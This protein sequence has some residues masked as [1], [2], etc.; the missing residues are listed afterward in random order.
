MIKLAC[1]F[2]LSVTSQ[3]SNYVD[4]DFVLTHL[5]LDNQQYREFYKQRKTYKI[6][7]NSIFELGEAVSNSKLFEALEIIKPNVII[8]PDVLKDSAKT[9]NRTK[10]FLSEFSSKNTFNCTIAG[11]L[12]GTSLSDLIQC[13]NFY[14]SEPLINTICIPFDLN[15]IELTNPNLS[16]ELNWLVQRVFLTDFIEKSGLVCSNYN[17]HLLGVGLPVEVV[18]QSKHSWITSID[19]SAPVV[20]GLQNK[21]LFTLKSKLVRPVDYFS[22]DL[23]SSIIQT[24][25]L[26]IKELQKELC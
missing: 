1:E 26:N 12:Q 23:D 17:Y 16:M 15:I 20:A 4:Y 5:V 18:Y 2:P 8:A 13:Y 14:T 25:I 6:L 21:K 9:I 19:T 22:L 24:I 11:V 3:L 7:D 10:S